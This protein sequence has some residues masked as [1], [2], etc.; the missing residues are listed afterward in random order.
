MRDHFRIFVADVATDP[1]LTTESTTE[2]RGV[3]L[4]ANV[5]SVHSTPLIDAGELVG[6]VLR[7]MTAPVRLSQALARVDDF[8]ASLLARLH[9]SGKGNSKKLMRFSR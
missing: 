9:S 4:R 7:T 6:M 3:L 1:L 8:V 5:R 2:S